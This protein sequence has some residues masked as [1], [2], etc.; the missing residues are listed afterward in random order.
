MK[1]PKT[2]SKSP[3]L[4]VTPGNYGGGRQETVPIERIPALQR[5][6]CKRNPS[7]QSIESIYPPART[8]FVSKNANG[9]FATLNNL[10]P[11]Q[12]ELCRIR[13]S[14]VSVVVL[15]LSTMTEEAIEAIR[16]FQLYVDPYRH[17]GI[18]SDIPRLASEGF[19]D[20]LGLLYGSAK[21]LP[22]KFAATSAL[23][24]ENQLAKS[25]FDRVQAELK[26]PSK[27]TRRRADNQNR[28]R[29]ARKKKTRR[30]KNGRQNDLF[31]K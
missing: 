16:T 18:D 1:K 29:L 13:S 27:K 31:K 15:D 11:I 6:T 23:F 12:P 3:V 10:E 20:A 22:G 2:A 24:L 30:K 17:V 26:D 21:S 25:T 8:I 19:Y 28:K 9:T 5:I 14:R 4:E 7:T